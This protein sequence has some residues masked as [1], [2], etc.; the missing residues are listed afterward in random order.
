[1]KFKTYR[2]LI[3]L[4]TIYGVETWWMKVTDEEDLRSLARRILRK[5]FGPVRDTGEWRICYNVALNEPIEGHD[6]LI[7][8]HDIVKF[9]EST[10]DKIAVTHG[11]N[12]GGT[13]A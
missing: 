9:I 5:I 10:G 4:A 13:G 12:V 11:E 1:M 2:T 3:H 7:E 6:E 8:G